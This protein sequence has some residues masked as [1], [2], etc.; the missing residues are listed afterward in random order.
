M[1]LL[2]TRP[3]PDASLSAQRLRA[4]GHEVIISPVIET[5]FSD[6]PLAW[7][8][9]HDFAVTSRNGVRA[10]GLL[11]SDEMR[12]QARVF[13]VGDASAALALTAGFQHVQSASGTVDDLVALIAAQNPVC[14]HYVC[15]RDRKGD[16]ELKLG[17]QGTAVVLVERYR[18]DFA[19]YLTAEARNALTAGTLEGVVLY[20][21]R[22]AEAFR[23]LTQWEEFSYSTKQITYFCLAKVIP[24]V[25]DSAIGARFIVADHPDEQSLFDAVAAFTRNC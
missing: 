22:A 19:R 24:S 21:A 4:L 10:L 15:G 6:E 9:G 5:H 12:K 13:A 16:L 25:F 14:V 20:S 3:E 8:P 17:A 7:K 18:A 23:L 11:S 1:R 2:M